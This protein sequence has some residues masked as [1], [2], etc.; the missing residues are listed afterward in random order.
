MKKIFGFLLL[1]VAALFIQSCSD[2]EETVTTTGLSVTDKDGNNLTELSFNAA[3]AYTMIGVKTDGDWT[4]Q[5]PEA[6]TTWLKI[7]PHA[8]YGWQYT[9]TTATNT[10]AYIRVSVEKNSGE[11][12]QS[13]ITLTS[14]GYTQV[15]TVTQKGIGTDPDDPFES[16]WTMVGKFKMGY[17]LGNT[18]ESNPS[19]SWWEDKIKNLSGSE[20][21][22]AYE[23]AWGQPVITQE[24][25]DEIHAQGFNVIRIP[26]TWAPH[27]DE[28]DVID[29][30]WMNRVEEVVKYALKDSGY[31]IINAMHDVGSD[32]WLTTD[33]DAYATSTVKYQTIWRQIAERFKDYDDHLIFES[34]NEILDKNFSWTAPAAGSADYETVNKLQQDFVN[35]VRSTG[36]NNAYRNL[37]V[38][39][40]S[41]TGNSA[42]AVSSVEKPNDVHPNHIYFTVHSY[43]PYNFCNDNSGV[44][45]AGNAYDWNIKVFDD[46][47]KSQIDDIIS[48]VKTRANALDMPFIFGE[49]GAIDE[50]K[51]MDER[52]KYATYVATSL[53][54]E[55]TTGL[56]W[57]GLYDRKAKD[58][59][60]QRI[61][62]ALKA[63]FLK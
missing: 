10:R 9:D 14:G 42:A 7:T 23:T 22:E 51:S 60:E 37:G 3:E 59:Y 6:D 4:A 50:N 19:G 28:N 41:A 17:N 43:D 16:V 18:L 30:T 5:V 46:D 26:V 44:D 63:V 1:F 25:I 58:W 54:N 36:G 21:V 48:M 34:F 47:C 11:D 49:F 62:D 15:V 24:T 52:V 35:V 12:R 39:T 40:Y 29:A 55:H 20:L 53:K 57:M 38:T 13:T 61:V 32:A 8:G 33:P 2:S 31:V 45:D 27:M 56:W